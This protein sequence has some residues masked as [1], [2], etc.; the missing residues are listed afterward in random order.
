VEP[1]EPLG[2]PRSETPLGIAAGGHL[3]VGTGDVSY[4]DLD[5]HLGLDDDRFA[6]AYRPV[7]EIAGPELGIEPPAENR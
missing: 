2:V 3:V 5:G 6:P 1:I 7:L 4:V